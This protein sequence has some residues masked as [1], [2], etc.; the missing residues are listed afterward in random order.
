MA[1]NRLVTHLPQ[2]K[3]S[4]C[5][6]PAEQRRKMIILKCLLLFI[7]PTPVRRWLNDQWERFCLSIYVP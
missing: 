7:T 6:L 4:A 2:E 1:A 5:L 3:A